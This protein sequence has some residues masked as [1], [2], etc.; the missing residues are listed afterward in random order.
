M[1]KIALFIILA[2]VALM[3]PVTSGASEDIVL[4]LGSNTA[5][6]SGKEKAID[7]DKS[8]IP[9]FKD[10]TVYIPVRFIA[11]SF[12]FTVNYSEETEQI[13]LESTDKKVVFRVGE[14]EISV[15][16]TSYN[17]NGKVSFV[18]QNRSYLPLRVFS[19]AI[20]K[21][22]C[23]DKGLIIIGNEEKKADE[24]GLDVLRNKL[25]G[26][27]IIG[28]K[29]NLLKKIPYVLDVDVDI[30]YSSAVG[31]GS[32]GGKSSATVQN[33][34]AVPEVSA[35]F[36]E[37]NIQV[38]GVDE[39]DII[40]TDGNYIYS[41]QKGNV[42]IISIN[43]ASDMKLS[44]VIKSEE[45]ET[46]IELYADGDILTVIYSVYDKNTKRFYADN[47]IKCSI[48]DISDRTYPKVSHSY[49]TDGNYV[50][51]RK[52]ADN[53]Y[54]I[55]T[56]HIWKEKGEIKLPCIRDFNFEKEEK[57][58]NLNKC[59]FLP[60]KN[61]NSFVTVSSV[62][63]TKPD[64]KVQSQSYLGNGQE[65]YMSSES[66]YISAQTGLKTN[67]YKFI[68]DNGNVI[69][70]TKATVPGTLVNQ[71]SMDEFNGNFRIATTYR[72]NG[73]LM[74]G[75]FIFD[76]A[77]IERGSVTEIAPTEQIY[78][79]RFVGNKAYMVTFRNTDPLFV[80]DLGDID[81]PK[82]LGKLKIPGYSTYLHPVDENNILGFGMDA[83]ENG[84]LSG[85][86]MALFDVSEVENP[87][88]KFVEKI[89][90]RNTSSPLINN[91][92]ALL[93]MPGKNLLAF[94]VNEYNKHS[95]ESRPVAKIYSFDIERGFDLRGEI[96]HIDEE[97]ILKSGDNYYF[98]HRE[99]ERI[100]YAND[101]LFTISSKKIQSNKFEDLKFISDI[102]L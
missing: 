91:H 49:T 32:G 89:G 41:V 95:T 50:S 70:N 16:G 19:E 57:E 65:I 48:F 34:S 76:R 8:V 68:L 56:A 39:A 1:K 99:I 62:N 3:L 55:T 94:P 75:M 72:E 85:M 28:S 25:T 93:Y 40:K 24:S 20:G 9:V 54:I 53:L 43:P 22:V 27:E 96:H 86:K 69:Y 100:I 6:V 33:S 58:I 61:Y 5:L 82:I 7:T 21:K 11:E 38:K 4:Y 46:P 14:N 73:T 12:G 44:S 42:N 81:N 98:P 36:S 88:Q 52:I 71:F 101:S 17:L 45:N 64:K 59:Y 78:S 18:Y 29:E 79:V 97:D 63:V 83:D 74:N 92:K 47:K 80:L 10:A 60:E 31:G 26:L 2:L 67:I 77:M 13:D 15:D 102:E 37:T 84:T 23:Y 30:E 66:L 35:D 51:S 87:K 90:E